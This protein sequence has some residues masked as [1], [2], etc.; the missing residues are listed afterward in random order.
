MAPFH[1]LLVLV[2]P[3]PVV[4]RECESVSSVSP[5]SDVTVTSDEKQPPRPPVPPADFDQ[6]VT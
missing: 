3:L 5:T 1:E 2:V 6:S 4:S